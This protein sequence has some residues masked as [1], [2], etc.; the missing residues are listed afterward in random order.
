MQLGRSSSYSSLRSKSNR[1]VQVWGDHDDDHNYDQILMRE[2]I[3]DDQPHHQYCLETVLVLVGHTRRR[4]MVSSKHLNNPLLNALIEKSSPS[5]SSSSN[6]K[7]NKRSSA[8]DNHIIFVKCEVPL[9]TISSKGFSRGVNWVMPPKH[10]TSI[11]SFWQHDT[12]Q[13]FNPTYLSVLNY[14]EL[15]FE[16]NLFSETDVET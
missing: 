5:P 2:Q 7:Q 15:A 13:S 10:G 4:Y 12:A 11:T 6:N 16:L 1:E 14:K 8:G 3:S 9:K